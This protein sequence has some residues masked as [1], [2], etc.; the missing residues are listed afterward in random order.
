M[1]SSVVACN[2]ELLHATV[3]LHVTKVYYML[4]SVVEFYLELLYAVQCC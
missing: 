3:L 1:L 2:L 4:S